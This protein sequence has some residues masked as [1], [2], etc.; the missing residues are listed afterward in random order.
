MGCF[1]SFRTEEVGEGWGGEDVNEREE[2]VDEA[3]F[4]VVNK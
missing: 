2:W 1:S 3:D 4:F